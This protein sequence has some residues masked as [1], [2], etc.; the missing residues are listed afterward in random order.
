M[1]K[2]FLFLVLPL[3]LYAAS[4]EFEVQIYKKIANTLFPRRTRIYVWSDTPKVYK[5]LSAIPRVIIVQ[6]KEMADILFVTH[7]TTL[8]TKKMK[9]VTNY[10][11]L[12]IY[13]ESAIGGFYWQ[14]G[15][16]ILLF[17][18]KN[19]QKYHCVLPQGMQK[20]SEDSI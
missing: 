19:L 12:K 13:K 16:P 10:R 9:F 8:H 15:R 17:L 14:K 5:I 18:R 3:F 20:Y 6:N 7:D 2:I 1:K 4:S 11:L